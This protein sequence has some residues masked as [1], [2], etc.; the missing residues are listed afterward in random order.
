MNAIC[1]SEKEVKESGK[2]AVSLLRISTPH[3][4][5]SCEETRDKPGSRRM[6]EESRSPR[7]PSPDAAVEGLLHYLSR[8]FN[9]QLSPLSIIKRERIFFRFADRLS[10]Q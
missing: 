6:R 5:L 2:D 1:F 8:I 9:K 7:R 4:N 10:L 3:A